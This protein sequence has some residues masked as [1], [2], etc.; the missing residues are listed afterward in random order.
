MF[1]AMSQLDISSLTPQERLE[2]IGR[3]WDSLAP[4]DMG[5]TP[6]QEAEL[7]RRMQSFDDNAKVAVSWGVIED[8]LRNRR[9]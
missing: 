4:E 1:R 2:L 7:G 6:A 8:D 5:L 3:L 9:G